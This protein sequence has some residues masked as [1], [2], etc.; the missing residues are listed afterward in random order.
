[1]KS[2][3]IEAPHCIHILTFSCYHGYQ[4]LN[5][6][7]TRHW[8][9]RATDSACLEFNTRLIAYVF[10][11]EHVHMMIQPRLASMVTD[12]FLRRVKAPVARKAIQHL[13]QSNPAWLARISR[14]RGHRTERVF[15]QS[16]G[17]YDHCTYSDTEANRL[18]DYIHTNPVR[19]GLV[20]R[21]QDWIWSSAAW[22]VSGKPGPCV[23]HGIRS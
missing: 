16:G 12:R 20:V 17:G 6:E 1:M 11:P 8:L 7:R 23:V 18:I 10:M 22:Y 15:W 19:K 2:S 14:K 13:V 5:A 9:A 21:P 4:F 3:F